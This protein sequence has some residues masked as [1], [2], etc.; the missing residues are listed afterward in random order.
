LD[1]GVRSGR[2]SAGETHGQ[3][4][5]LPAALIEQESTPLARAAQLPACQCIERCSGA[6]EQAPPFGVQRRFTD[7]PRSRTLHLQL[8]LI[9]LG[10]PTL[11]P[12]NNSHPHSPLLTGS[13]FVMTALPKVDTKCTTPSL[14]PTVNGNTVRSFSTHGQQSAAKGSSTTVSA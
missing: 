2:S 11:T 10:Y 5:H 8:P 13:L 3:L 1:V 9:S 12:P 4:P 7:M 6:V 14:I